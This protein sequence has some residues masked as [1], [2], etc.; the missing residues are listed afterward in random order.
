MSKEMSI[1]KRNRLLISAIII[2]L[3]VAIC[4]MGINAYIS[5]YYH[6][7]Q[8]A[9]EVTRLEKELNNG[10]TVKQISDDI[11]AFEP[12]HSDIGFIFYPGA[13][14]EYTAYAPLM[15]SLAQ[16][17]ITCIIPHMPGNIAFMNVNAADSIKK[18]YPDIKRWYVGGHS[19]GGATS[20]IY[21]AKHTDEYEGLILLAAY[22]TKDLSESGL[23]VISIYG[24]EDKVLSGDAYSRNISNLPSNYKQY[25]I[26][27][28]NHAYFG[29]YG[30]QEG[31]GE[32]LI[33]NGEQ[34]NT[35]IDY[36]KNGIGI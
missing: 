19:L 27:G 20:S 17:G 7:N 1:K 31:D 24:S 29:S 10:V 8:Q 36:I 9:I 3:I 22:S 21:I 13:K 12:E 14:V 32:A 15:N 6:A 4:Y 26:D 35:A 25:V 2:A 34:I 30:P 18:M 23:N 11:I 5:D 28:G 33:T 16:N